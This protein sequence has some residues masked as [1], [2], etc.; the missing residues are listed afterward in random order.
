MIF[1][2]SLQFFLQI[3]CFDIMTLDVTAIY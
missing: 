2:F 3:T 1:I